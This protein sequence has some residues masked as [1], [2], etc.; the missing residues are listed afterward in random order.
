MNRKRR[1]ASLIFSLLLFGL[2][3]MA[4]S[5]L[6]DG[7]STARIDLTEENVYSITP[8]T[9]RIIRSLEEDVTIYGFFSE[10]THPKLAPLVPEVTDLLQEYEEVSGGRVN[11]QIFDPKADEAVE[12]MAADRF[13]VQSAPFRTASKYETGI[14]NAYFSIVVQYADQYQRYGFID[15]I[16]V[17]PLPD[18]DIDVRLR[19]LEYDVTRAIKK[20]VYGF[21]ATN[22]LF[23]RIEQPVRLEAYVSSASL[24]EMFADVPTAL[25]EAV[26]ELRE[27]GG[28]KFQFEQFDPDT[29]PLAQQR[30]AQLGLPALSL[31]FFGEDGFY[32]YGIL[33]NGGRLEQ[34]G[35]A[36]ETVSKA[37]IREAIEASLRRNTPGFLKTIGVVAPTPPQLPPQLAMQYPQPP[38]E[39]E[40]LKR[41][42]TQE[43]QVRDVQL[44]EPGGVG[45]DVDTLLVLKPRELS[46]REVYHLDQYLMRGGR[47]VLCAGRYESNTSSGSLN[48]NPVDTGLEGW[49]EHYGITL[50][51]KLVL[52]DQ[53]YP[54]PIPSYRDTALGRIRSYEMAPYPYLVQVGD[55]GFVN[56]D[57]TST[58]DTVGIYWGSPLSVAAL[59]AEPAEDTDEASQEPEDGTSNRDL[60][61]E[62]LLRSS[63]RSWTETD[64]LGVGQVDYVVPAETEPELLAVAV[65]GQFD[66]YF[67]E[68][69]PPA[70]A[71]DDPQAGGPDGATLKRSPETRLIV[72]GN[73]EFLS[74][75]VARAVGQ[76]D[77]FFVENLRFVQN[78]IDWAGVDNELAA[79]RSR[80]LKSRR[81][82]RVEPGT[83]STIEIINYL[84]PAGVL[85]A[86]GIFLYRKRRQ[87]KPV[88]TMPAPRGGTA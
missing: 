28:E 23:E 60:T 58:L 81:L 59:Q 11:V 5:Y 40:E 52:D 9:K 50:E 79:I 15:L 74:D 17:D 38:P 6:L 29:D 41:Y 63:E 39:F 72:V 75:N 65:R 27:A 49:L 66:S 61:Y 32:L 37:S 62:P 69:G 55:D 70:A 54:L 20:V 22:E 86:F 19:N 43:Y 87:Q 51:Q 36:A 13:G 24:P 42:L 33:D 12:D 82:E 7:W 85:L 88:V 25:E 46:E 21:R 67:A 4:L 68:T 48:I 83:Q 45:S 56:R 57:I 80:G 47:V 34:I 2:N 53:N 76:F 18:G 73:S 30:L 1:I 10:R 3:L 35:L 77:G 14:V 31:S 78:V 26:A 8:A 16:E 44:G 71:P 84:I 64:T